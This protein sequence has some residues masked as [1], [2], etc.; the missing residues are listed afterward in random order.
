MHRA[1]DG[2]SGRHF[3]CLYFNIAGPFVFEKDPL[4]SSVGYGC[5]VGRFDD[6]D[7]LPAVSRLFLWA[8]T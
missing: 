5:T 7:A 6:K 8:V 2:T 1:N 4:N 3:S